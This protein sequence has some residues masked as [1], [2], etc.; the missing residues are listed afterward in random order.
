MTNLF[1]GA[2][3]SKYDLVVKQ[4]LFILLSFTPKIKQSLKRNML[5]NCNN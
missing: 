3:F 1:I 2:S 5:G 4:L